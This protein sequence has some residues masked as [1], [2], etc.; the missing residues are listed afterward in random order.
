MSLFDWLFGSASLKVVRH[1]PQRRAST[2]LVARDNTP[3]T[4]KRGWR[5]SGKRWSGPYACR[6]GTWH[7]KIEKR[8]DRF[9]VLIKKPPEVVRNHPKF[10]CFHNDKS[11]WMRIHLHHNPADQDVN[12]VIAY[13][14][15]LLAESFRL[16][17]AR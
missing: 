8:G 3:L 14:E 11:G 17:G 16:A 13:V 2:K 15:R 1:T 6:H 5:R 9:N 12:A 10:V 4:A 7:G